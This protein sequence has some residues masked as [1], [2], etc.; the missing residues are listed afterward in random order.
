MDFTTAYVL[1]N[2][3]V[4]MDA[5][6]ASE[7]SKICLEVA[8][9]ATEY[10]RYDMSSWCV[11]GVLSFLIIV[12][13]AISIGRGDN[14]FWKITFPVVFF[15][16]LAGGI[17]L[18]LIMNIDYVEYSERMADTIE[19]EKQ[20]AGCYIPDIQKQI[21]IELQKLNQAKGE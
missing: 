1:A 6:N 21:L 8:K 2:I 17:H 5:Q 20:K 4:A 16:A 14:G 19:Q 11:M 15:W 18:Y 3:A 9:S 13:P 10:A 7:T 12:L